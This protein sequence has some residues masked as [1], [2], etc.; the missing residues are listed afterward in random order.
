MRTRTVKACGAVA[1]A[2]VLLA[3]LAGCDP[4]NAEAS[5]EDRRFP[6][7]GRH[8]TIDAHETAVTVVTGSG[9]AVEV[10]RELRGSAAAGGNAS[11]S[12]RDGTLSL[13]VD[14]SGVVLSCESEHRV[15]VP[16]D[17]EVRITGAGAA[18]RLEGLTGDVT[19]ALRYDS[20]LRVVDPAGRLRLWNGGGDIAVTRARSSDV[21]AETAADGT[22][23][24]TFA[25][26]PRRVEARAA[27][28]V[29]ITLPSGPET[30]RVDAAGA[31]VPNDPASDRLIVARAVDG[32]VKV[33]K[34]R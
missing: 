34:A 3:C 29:D 7:T 23:R 19:A 5:R 10:E 14:C 8:L 4:R 31:D 2:A 25:T 26:A 21:E 12:L 6:F 20:T 32:S 9:G 1:G 24:L 15:R 18:V 22:V 13:R 33:R 28:S 30:Y 27:E 11:W 16:K 17:I